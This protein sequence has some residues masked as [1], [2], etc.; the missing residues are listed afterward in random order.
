MFFFKLILYVNFA[1]QAQI[2]GPV[3]EIDNKLKDNSPEQI[4]NIEKKWVKDDDNDEVMILDGLV[5]SKMKDSQKLK[6]TTIYDNENVSG[7]VSG[8]VAEKFTRDEEL[9]EYRAQDG[10]TLQKI[11][12]KIYGTT[13]RWK[14]IYL[15]NEDRLPSEVVKKGMLIKYRANNN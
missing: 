4:K 2:N 8:M 9:L 10:D 15:L 11:S 14:E 3:A 5:R 1:V 7:A 13:K 12:E 6:A